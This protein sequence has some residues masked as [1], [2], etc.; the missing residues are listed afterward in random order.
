MEEWG[1]AAGD[2]V[3]LRGLSKLELNGQ[4]GTVLL[5]DPSQAQLGRLP[6]M[7]HNGKRLSLKVE[8]L[9]KVQALR[10]GGD[11]GAEWSAELSLASA[12]KLRAQRAAP[13]LVVMTLNLQYLASFPKDPAVA[14]RN[15]D[16]SEGCPVLR[17][18]AA[19]GNHL[20]S[21]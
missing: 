13:R 17:Q 21:A 18:T 6:V 3:E 9:A 20:V 19:A 12:R 14:R 8:N 15:P 4:K 7:L 5:L 2:E 10:T 1:F 11:L 16:L